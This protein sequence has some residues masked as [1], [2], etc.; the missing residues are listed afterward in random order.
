MTT[1]FT[2]LVTAA[3]DVLLEYPE[4]FVAFLALAVIGMSGRLGRVLKSVFRI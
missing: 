2:D 4:I 1:T 3:T